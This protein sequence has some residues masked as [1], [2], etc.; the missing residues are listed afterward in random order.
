MRI[1][2]FKLD[3]EQS[4]TRDTRVDYDR[5]K[6]VLD[7]IE[8]RVMQTP[9]AIAVAGT[10]TLT[11][12]E[13]WDQSARLAHLLRRCKA[14]IA[15]VLMDDTA[16][17]LVA[18]LG[19][20][21]AG[22]VYLPAN[23]DLPLERNRFMFADAPV[24]VVITEKKYIREANRL[25]WDCPKLRALVCLDSLD[26]HAEAESLSELMRIDLWNFIGES[27][28]DDISG[29]GWRDSY[30]GGDLPAAV[31]QEYADNVEKKLAPLVGPQT[32][33]LEIGCSSGITMFRL[34]P[35]AGFYYG[36]DLSASILAHTERERQR[37]AL[38]HVRLEARAAH[39]VD[40][41][42]ERDFDLVIINSVVQNWNGHN[43]LRDV[44]RKV[45]PLLRDGARIFIGDVM[46]LDCRD[47]L[48]ASLL[49]FKRQNAGRGFQTKT[50]WS[51]E[52]FLSRSFFDDLRHDL[53]QIDTIEHSAKIHAIPCELTDFRYDTL[54]TIRR[55]AH[56]TPDVPRHK[57]QYD[58][59]DV[60]AESNEPLPRR[61]HGDDLAYIL[62]TSGTTGRPKGVAVGHR[63]LHNYIR[64][65]AR[66]YFARGGGSMPLFTSPSFDLTLTSIF[67]PL[68]LGRT[69]TPFRNDDIDRLLATIFTTPGIDAVKLTPAHISIL[70]QLELPSTQVET[71]IA[72]G[73]DLLPE[74]CDALRAMNPAIRIFNEYGPTEA[75]VGCTISLVE[76]LPI[77]IGVPIDNTEIL[78]LDSELAPLPDGI[79]GELCVAGDCLALGYWND[80]LLT[81]KK[82][83]EREGRRIYRTGD[84]A[85]R[86]PDGNLLLLGRIDQQ[87]KIRGTRIE[88]GEI[89]SALRNISEI[90]DAVVVDKRDPSGEKCLCAYVISRTGSTPD[91]LRHELARL[92][93]E[94]MVPQHIVFLDAF[95]LNANGKLDRRALPEPAAI[96]A[97]RGVAYAAPETPLQREVAEVWRA[98]LG[99]ERVGLDDNFFDIG[100]HSLKATQ[101]VSR[102]HKKLGI[103]VALR[104][105]FRQPT[106]RT[107]CAAIDGRDA[108]AYEPIARIETRELYDVSHA[109]ARL[110]LL[111]KIDPDPI[112]YNV[113][114]A[115]RVEGALDVG[116]LQ[117]AFREVIARYEILRTSFVEV[118]GRPRQRVQDEVAFA[119][120]VR[121]HDDV[122]R[123]LHAD[124]RKPF[125]LSHAPLLRV[126][127]LPDQVLVV[128]MHHIVTDGW[129]SAL[130]VRQLLRAYRENGSAA[131]PRIHYRDYA[132]W[133]NAQLERETSHRDYWHARFATLPPPLEL[134]LD[135]ARSAVRGVAGDA[136][137]FRIDAQTTA[138]LRALS[139]EHGASLFMLLLA[140]FD[141]LLHRYSGQS[142]LV[143][144][145]PIAGRTHPDLEE[146][147][148]FFT[149]TLALRTEVDGDV[150]FLELLERVKT[151]ALEAFEHQL[152]PF[153]RLVGELAL[154]RDT[155][156][157]PLFSVMFA[158]QNN[159][160]A[161]LDLDNVKVTPLAAPAVTSKF[162]LS[163]FMSEKGSE[164]AATIEYSTEL[165]SRERMQLAASHFTRLL[166]GIARDPHLRIADI[167]LRTSD[168][169]ARVTGE[170]RE[171]EDVLASFH[172][173]AAEHPET[174]AVISARGTLTYGELASRVDAYAANLELLHVGQP[175]LVSAPRSE[176]LVVALLG[177][178]QAGGAY[179]YLDPSLPQERRE[180][181]ARDA[182]NRDAAV[183][184]LV[185]TSGST[186]TPKGVLGT[187]RCLSNLIAWQTRTIGRGLR[188]AF[189]AALGFDVAV[190]EVLFAA[191]TGG[192][193]V[194][195]ADDERL[196]RR[197]LLDFVERHEIELLTMPF[198]ALALL[199]SERVGAERMPSLRHLVT[200]GEQLHVSGA[201]RTFLQARPDVLL[202]NQ[203]GPSE[204]HVVTSHIVGASLDN[205]VELPPIGTPIDNTICRIV[206]AQF[207]AVPTGVAGELLL[208]GANVARGYIGAPELTAAK[209]VDVDG[210]RMYRSGDLCRWRP[211]GTIDLLGRI[212]AQLK[213]RGYRV[214]PGEVEQALLALDDVRQACVVLQE[215]DL[216]AFIVSARE[217]DAH[218]LHD[219]LA[220]TLPAPLIP[221]RFYRVDA[222]PMTSSGKI[223]RKRAG[224]LTAT[225][226]ASTTLAATPPSTP[227]E[228]LLHEVE[229]A[230]LGRD[231]GIDD[232]FFA[233][234]GHS[235]AATQLV[236]RLR[237]QT[238]ID[239]SLLSVFRRPTIR[240]LA[241]YVDELREYHER[242]DRDCYALLAQPHARKLFAMPPILGYGIAFRGLARAIDGVA[243]VYGF[244]FVEEDVLTTYSSV[245][246]ELQPDG[247]LVLFGYSAGGSLAFEL[248]RRLA[249]DGRRV[250]DLIFFDTFRPDAKAP[251]DEAE[252]ERIVAENLAYF[253]AYIAADAET[254]MF[255]DNSD[256]R[257]LL[258]RKMAAYVRTYE[259]LTNE[260][261]VDANLHLITSGE[262]AD[263]ERH[264]RWRSAT[265][266][267]FTIRRGAGGHTDMLFEPNLATNA[268]VLRRVL[269]DVFPE[270]RR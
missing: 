158:L 64:W 57:Q 90:D 228:T 172:R 208:G 67:V 260:D 120:D 138:A 31:M 128:T 7:L 41:I 243:A 23:P 148:G 235:L 8:A 180:F 211:D 269:A 217:L 61:P 153:D 177:T 165:F 81:A 72:G 12:A 10:R 40:G 6:T 268:E 222:L 140:A 202:H 108:K 239:V 126:A 142:D 77:T 163:L 17:M 215:K 130:F 169:P 89:E 256:V 54:L 146:Q 191:A 1:A 160:R 205:L 168:D 182:Q 246:R 178:L 252:V 173:F 225:P 60:A 13:L 110:W 104:E 213:V 261:V 255:V 68:V 200:S 237:Q 3:V 36:I 181:I 175:V 233:S 253:D 162:D 56:A 94:F 154:P 147:L 170:Q 192:T 71:I 179:V 34:A 32:R 107:L 114:E 186:G 29:G 197:R 227:T 95:P 85:R 159:E 185:Y 75:T 151:T 73:E 212:D 52:L 5:T 83:V 149:N 47:A 259:R 106:V 69:V 270:V 80:D 33:V 238:G 229:R 92:L 234:G 265:T 59:R 190:Q 101:V 9:D 250:S 145:S 51:N 232:D 28:T 141:A 201:L 129:S 183:A 137:P 152:Y 97:A 174:P 21:R 131:A 124:A 223:D 241:A 49:D 38:D 230:I 79:A 216:A 224:E 262:F 11:Y 264:E 194:I 254:R 14:A 102:L 88:L 266:G 82:F 87:V 127:L 257:A 115:L 111:Q 78:I 98:V 58:L 116:A 112:A 167:D 46:D 100:G 20:L 37:L 150:T 144:G 209:F 203:Y 24:D 2:D 86:L 263:D 25:Q 65:A 242:H 245:I 244:D 66:H 184:Y 210:E 133:Q 76:G 109:Q 155:S 70:R 22:V 50:D 18:I 35:R 43:Y 121:D 45:I 135:H 267:R 44:L 113:Q 96:A 132:A 199:F 198:S 118:D 84:R 193:L 231:L 30:T 48:L 226:L 161:A 240:A 218:A 258:V 196:D 236:S 16:E 105:V 74:Q 221:S 164:L 136:L 123:Y 248:A 187:R 91:A 42:A 39:D 53:P 176:D 134:P 195:P 103:E 99:V 157:T 204:T 62:Y 122:E 15:G 156:R 117:R 4:S 143:V 166:E 171:F 219:A 249:S 55:D 214:E 125:D 251:S 139:V 26:V 19:V 188:T 93:P 247:D 27:A 189:Y 206:D 63:S 220:K 119:I 207:R